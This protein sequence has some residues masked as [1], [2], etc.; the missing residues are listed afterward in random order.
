[1]SINRRSL[2]RAAALCALLPT[3]HI[4]RSQQWPSRPIRIVHGY[5]GGT[6]PDTLS[7]LLAPGLSERLGQPIVVEPKPGAAGRIAAKYVSAQPGDGHTLLMLTAGD[8]VVAALDPNVQYKLLLD[9]SFVSSVIEFPFLFCV[10]AGSPIKSLSDLFAMARS[11]PGQVSYGTPGVGT[12]QSM[13]G[14]LLQKMAGVELLH[15]PYRGNAFPDLLGGRVDFLIA[16]PSVSTSLIQGGKIRAIGVT[17]SG[18]YP[19]LPDVAPVRSLVPGY[20][21]NSWLGLGVPKSTPDAVVQRLSSSV[22]VVSNADAVRSA[23]TSAG[24]VVAAG[25][26]EAFR[27]RVEADVKKWSSFSGRIRLEG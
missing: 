2:V 19:T 23:I 26:S 4:A 1:M 11:R 24:S 25:T 7:R 27:T 20:E 5:D 10:A 15:V 3:A 6:N 12:T 9:F 22:Q 17:S 16:A 21:V 8:A 14:E 18:A 13:A